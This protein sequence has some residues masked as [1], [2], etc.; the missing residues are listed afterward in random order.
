[1]MR[2]WMIVGMAVASALPQEAAPA[3]YAYAG[4]LTVPAASH[5]EFRE[6]IF[7]ARTPTAQVF[8]AAKGKLREVRVA[9][10]SFETSAGA[11]GGWRALRAVSLYLCR[12]NGERMVRIAA[13]EG[14][15]GEASV[16]PLENVRSD[17]YLDDVVGGETLSLRLEYELKEAVREPIQL[18]CVVTLRT[19]AA[20]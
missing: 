19:R 10:V 1:M 5:L 9:S 15:A 13:Q 6:S 14:W 17:F 12:D 4:T 18:Q 3:K 16:M 8:G 2:L 20:E 11:A 7:S